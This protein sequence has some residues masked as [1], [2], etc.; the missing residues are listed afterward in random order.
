MIEAKNKSEFLKILSVISEEAVRLSNK[1]LKESSDPYVQKYSEQL[2]TDQKKYGSL[3]EQD[4]ELEPLEDEPAGDE[5]DDELEPLDDEPGE[6]DV[7]LADEEPAEEGAEKND[8][9]E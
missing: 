4:D 5:G 3:S 2:K 7:E 1:S 8:N 9:K 6:E